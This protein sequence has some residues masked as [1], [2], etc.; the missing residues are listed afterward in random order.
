MKEMKE[1]RNQSSTAV[2]R[3]TTDLMVYGHEGWLECSHTH[4]HPGKKAEVLLKWGHNMQADGLCRKEGLKAWVI[5]PEGEKAELDVAEGSPDYYLL[6]FV[7]EKEGLYRVVAQLENFYSIDIE[8]KH[9]Q[10]SRRE[11]P[12]AV[13]SVAYT[14]IYS[15]VVPVG[16]G[17][18][19]NVCPAGT[20]MEIGPKEWLGWQAGSDLELEVSMN[21]LPMADQEVIMAVNGPEGY[22]SSRITTD[23]KG[24]ARV[25]LQNPGK[26]LFLARTSFPDQV[27]GSHEKRQVTGTL[28]VLV[29]RVV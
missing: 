29:T 27:A 17:L 16:H 26:Y 8:G 24:S 5:N 23:K 28:T 3:D 25:N 19:G 6:S 11:C 1:M 20:L 14:Q 15:T 7:P 12:D 9:R 18:T 21:Q 13:E 10:G 4:G 22:N 2:F